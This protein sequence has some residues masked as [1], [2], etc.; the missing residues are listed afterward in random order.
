[1]QI[2]RLKKGNNDPRFSITYEENGFGLRRRGNV[3]ELVLPL[4]NL[5][6]N[7]LHV[8]VDRGGE[9]KEGKNSSI[10]QL[11]SHFILLNTI[12]W[13]TAFSKP[14]DTDN[15]IIE[16]VTVITVW[17]LTPLWSWEWWK[18]ILNFRNRKKQTEKHSIIY[19]YSS[20]GSLWFIA[21]GAEIF[22]SNDWNRKYDD[23]ISLYF[24]TY[25]WSC[26]RKIFYFNNYNIFATK[27]SIYIYVII[28]INC[29]CKK[30][31]KSFSFSVFFHPLIP[32]SFRK[33]VKKSFGMFFLKKKMELKGQ[34]QKKCIC[35][36]M[37]NNFSS[38]LGLKVI[39][40]VPV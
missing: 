20:W 5:H 7:H 22:G 27:Q 40:R 2:Y 33:K 15:P 26:G 37:R 1:M 32:S 28:I 21:K 16:T 18:L 11:F 38:N 14:P 13:L 31:E 30:F 12:E 17:H 35:Y 36:S 6:V 4:T 23:L 10:R 8:V 9:T 29:W 19:F 34:N 39:E 24:P 3:E 25:R